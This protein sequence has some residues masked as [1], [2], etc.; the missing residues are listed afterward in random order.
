LHF[1]KKL[2][3]VVYFFTPL[4]R[5]ALLYHET[6]LPRNKPG[7]RNLAVRLFAPKA[8]AEFSLPGKRSS[9]KHG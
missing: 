4:A 2:S 3:Q 9:S 6:K 5:F 1:S 7:S 8:Q